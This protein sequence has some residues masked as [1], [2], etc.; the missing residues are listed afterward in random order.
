[1]VSSRCL[2]YSPLTGDGSVTMP[3]D[4]QLSAVFQKDLVMNIFRNGIFGSFRHI[5][6]LS[7]T[8]PSLLAHLFRLGVCQMNILYDIPTLASEDQH[9]WNGTL[10]CPLSD[11]G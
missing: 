4:E 3:T 10:L 5:S 11:G 9:K 7:G 6:L 8:Y 2:F 1:M